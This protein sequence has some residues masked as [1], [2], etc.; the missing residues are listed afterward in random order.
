MIK[1]WILEGASEQPAATAAD[2][3]AQPKVK[4]AEPATA[5]VESKSSLLDSLAK[6]LSTPSRSSLTAA[7]KTGA[8]VRQLAEKSPLVRAEFS[9]FASEVEDSNL[10]AF[11][12]IK[13]N[14]SHLDV[15][16]TKITDKTLNIA[17]GY[18]NLTWINARN[19][20][21]SDSG[22]KHLSKLQYLQ[23]VNLSGTQVSDKG[24]GDL[25]S[26]KTLNEV[27]LWNSKVTESGV[28]KLRQALPNAKIIF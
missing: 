4:K 25:A 6:R 7:E 17:G 16:R 22:I 26:I 14:I 21:V 28:E 3:N 10:G 1:R 20:K 2:P 18:P 8:L 11:S 27:Y 12:G 5:Q 19:T 13:N 15:S 23:Y 24:M 9:S